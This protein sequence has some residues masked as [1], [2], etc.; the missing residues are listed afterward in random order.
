[1]KV[2]HYFKGKIP[3]MFRGDSTLLDQP[4]G[5]SFKGV[6]RKIFLSW[7]YKHIDTALYVG[8][9]NKAYYKNV[10]LK[11]TQ[12]VFAP[13]AIDNKRFGEITEEQERWIIATK[14]NAS[15]SEDAISIVFCGKLQVKKNPML[16]IQAV[17]KI[18]KKNVHLFIVGDGLLKN[19]LKEQAAN[20]NNIHFLPFQ[21]QS[22][23]PAVYKL[24]NIFCLPSQGP[25]ETWGL[26]VNEAMASGKAILVSNKAGCATDL[27]KNGINGY[28][29]ESGN[30]NDIIEKLTVMASNKNGLNIMG[31]SS[32]E[33]IQPW[34]FASI[35]EALSVL[36]R[37]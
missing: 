28:I 34:S 33:M 12:L 10:G 29:F 2:L 35:V 30:L 14:E 13:H 5:F 1:L 22:L 20:N 7:V 24:A 15:I 25:G 37:N 6:V 9:A 26:A 21:N 32:Y 17:N 4:S 16:L 36:L 19:E 31:K 27:V 18:Q 8:T 23:M 3:V 11:E